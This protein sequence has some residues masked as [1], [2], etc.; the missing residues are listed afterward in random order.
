MQ[1]R[2]P[3]TNYQIQ[4]KLTSYRGRG[5]SRDLMCSVER[6]RK[7]ATEQAAVSWEPE[8]SEGLAAE[9]RGDEEREEGGGVFGGIG[10]GI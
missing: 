6:E 7:A 10:G 8:L 1:F 4:F 9:I 5:A 2:L 3:N